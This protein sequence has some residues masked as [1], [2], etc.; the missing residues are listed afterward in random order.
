LPAG[1]VGQIQLNH[2]EN[3]MGKKLY[4]AAT[5]IAL[6]S[7]SGASAVLLSD[8]FEG[9]VV[10]GLPA[11][12]SIVHPDPSTSTTFAEVVDSANNTAGTGK[13][14]KLRTDDANTSVIVEYNFVADAAS[15][16]SAVRVDLS[17]AWDDLGATSHSDFLAVSLGEYNTSLTF[18]AA[19][20]RYIDLR[21][22]DNGDLI[23]RNAAGNSSYTD[24]SSGSHDLSIFVNDYD[25]QSISYT[26]LDIASHTLGANKAAYWLDGTLFFTSDM[27]LNDTTTG[28]TV[29]NTQNNLGKFG[30][31]STRA[32]VNL[33]YVVD[34]IE[35]TTIPEPATLGMIALFSGAMLFIRRRFMI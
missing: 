29:G 11:S 32:D 30:F 21:L 24:V 10:G 25:S 20:N 3:K 14:L 31:G 12:A 34:D 7:V 17:F 23:V 4:L 19:A 6:G 22:Y 9:D 8:N 35:I 13:G 27:D 15:Q 18:S 16:L 2:K 1:K 26:G 33:G 5:A 28:G